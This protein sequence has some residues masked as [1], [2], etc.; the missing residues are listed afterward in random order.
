[1][2][3]CLVN[4]R[5][6]STPIPLHMHMYSEV[7]NLQGVV[8]MSSSINKENFRKGPKYKHRKAMSRANYDTIVAG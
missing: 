8:S 4:S 1:M 3:E 7:M 5:M 6:H 2:F